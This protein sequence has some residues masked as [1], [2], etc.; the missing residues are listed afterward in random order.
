MCAIVFHHARCTPKAAHNA[1]VLT[2]VLLMTLGVVALL[3][4]Q[5]V[6]SARSVVA[7]RVGTLTREAPWALVRTIAMDFRTFHP[8]GM[9]KIGTT[10]FMSSVEVHDR[11]A[12]KGIG[13]LFKVDAAGN[14]LADLTLGEGPLYHP[15]GIDFDGSSIWI[16]LAEYRPNSRSIVYRVNPET[17]KATEVFRVADH[18]GAIVHDTDDGMLHGVSWGSRRFYRW[19]TA[20][21]GSTPTL[22][23]SHHLDYQDCKYLGEHLML[24]GG[25]TE[26]RQT[27]GATPFRLGGL[28]IVDLQRGRAVAQVPVRLWT[29]GGLAMTQNPVWVEPSADGLRAY[30]MPEDDRSAIYVYEV[31]TK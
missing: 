1:R 14:L 3:D 11:A 29:S 24:C 18:I 22:N 2:R 20:G 7:E 16:A 30:F 9:V 23:Y 5:G 12:G 6:R 10:W 15:S 26:M 27:P 19:N 28:E 21:V 8:Q 25:V 17:M 4:A 13:H 31:G